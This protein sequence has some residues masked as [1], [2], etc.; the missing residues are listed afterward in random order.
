MN[1]S[2]NAFLFPSADAAAK[3]LLSHLGHPVIERMITPRATV[4]EL[5]D[6]M[7][8]QAP[9]VIELPSGEAIA[10]V[11]KGRVLDIQGHPSSAVHWET[12]KSLW[13]APA[14]EAERHIFENVPASNRAIESLIA[15]RVASRTAGRVTQ[16]VASPS[17]GFS[18]QL[19]AAGWWN[20]LVKVMASHALAYVASLAGAALL[21]RGAM[22]GT[23]DPGWFWGWVLLLAISVPLFAYSSLGS[24]WLVIGFGG[25]L[26]QRL[27]AGSLAIRIER[28]AKKGAGQLLSQAIESE[29][30]EIS[31]LGGGTQTVLALFE[32]AAAIFV[33]TQGVAPLLL[34][35]LF[36]SWI[37]LT[38]A[39]MFR[40][41]FMVTRWVA[42]RTALT[43]NIVEKMNG[44]RTRIA[45][46]P[47][48]QWHTDEDEQLREYARIS[49]PFDRWQGGMIAVIPRG[50]LVIGIAAAGW[51]FTSNGGRETIQ[52]MAAAIF[53]VLLG[54]VAL[55]HLLWGLGQALGAWEAWKVA[56]ELFD[57]TGDQAPEP[58]D[59]AIAPSGNVLEIRDLSFRYPG[60]GRTVLSGCNLSIRPGDRLLIEGASGSGKSTLGNVIAGIRA[61]S[62]GLILSQGVDIATVG[63]T[64]WRKQ[65]ATAPQYHQNHVLAAPLLFNLLIGRNWPLRPGDAKEA[66]EVCGELGLGPLLE[67]MPAGMMEMVGDTGWQLSQGERSR[68]YLARAILQEAPLVILDESFAALDP[69]TLEQC[70]RCVLKRAPSLMVIAHP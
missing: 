7:S 25:L 64:H 1:P 39:C 43:H 40:Y 24:A 21:A 51:E 67:R 46:Q 22:S 59:Y 37:A 47:Y 3:A 8:R 66:A 26:K 23:W 12:V 28:I 14:Y 63:A 10:V 20:R 6:G 19:R 16:F 58:P 36:G 42:A 62:G 49:V 4:G 27:L 34:P 50:W 13:E 57:A 69:E 55:R 35:L 68:V 29:I 45:Q 9:S 2:N 44:H 41:T 15:T 60:T 38:L 61:P 32:L 31:M 70:L 52:P 30:L 11:S 33:L 56:S 65:V 5:A 53:G 48:S 17:T 18:S 54:M